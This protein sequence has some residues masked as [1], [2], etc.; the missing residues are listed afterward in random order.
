MEPNTAVKLA[1]AGLDK[2]YGVNIFCYGEG[3]LSIKRGQ[4]PKRFPNICKELGDLVRRGAKLA[5]CETCS[6]ARGLQAGEEIAGSKIG[7]LTGEFVDFFDR[8]SRLV[9]LGR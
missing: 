1:N 3:V 9:T 6:N 2:G 4:T 8:S 5:V 7:R